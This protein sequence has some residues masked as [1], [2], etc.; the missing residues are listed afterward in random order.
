M[1]RNTAEL[2]FEPVNDVLVVGR[3]GDAATETQLPSGDVVL[4][5]R[6]IVPRP[7][8]KVDTLDC[9]VGAAGLRKKV[10]GWAAGDVVEIQGALHRRFWRGPAGPVSRYE[11]AVSSARRVKRAAS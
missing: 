3:L 8:A 7:D 2:D 9:A 4:N 1:P 5:C 6:V 10:L 11:I